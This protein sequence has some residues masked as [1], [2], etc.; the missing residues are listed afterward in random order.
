MATLGFQNSYSEVPKRHEIKIFLT[1]EQ[2]L[3]LRTRAV[4][5]LTPDPHMPGPEG[6]LIRSV[7][8]DDAMRTAYYEKDSGVEHRNKYRIRSYNDSDNR[9]ILENKEKIDDRIAKSSALISRSCYDSI[10]QGDYEPLLEYDNPLCKEVYML[11]K[12]RLLKPAVIVEYQ[13]EA[14]IHPLS[15]VRITF[16][17]AIS[18]GINTLDMFD[19]KLI[20][21]PVFENREVVLEVKYGDYYPMYLAQLLKNNGTKQAVSKFV[22]C[23][24][25]LSHDYHI[26]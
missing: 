2:Y 13:R 9:I 25:K 3:E 16:D 6:Y 17:K 19:P 18:A 20:T 4:G 22:Y 26:L 21:E 15:M 12:S 1:Y 8:L 10:L 14:F 11:H 7:Y 5:I 23:M 24:D